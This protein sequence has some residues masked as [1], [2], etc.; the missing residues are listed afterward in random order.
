MDILQNKAQRSLYEGALGIDMPSSSMGD[1]LRERTRSNA[2][3]SLFFFTTAVLGWNKLKQVPHL[4]LC[5][6]IQQVTPPF[7]R[8]KVVLIPR[9]CYKS[10]IGSK[11]LP[12]WILVQKDFLGL[13]GPEHRILLVSHSSVNAQKQIKS[14]RQ[15]IERNQ[16]LQ[17]L[18]PELIP[19]L[20]KTT[21]TDTNLLFPRQGVYGEDT[22][23]CA[24][25]DTHLVSRHYTV[26]I[27]DDMEDEAAMQSPTVRQRVISWYKAA[28]ALFVDERDAFD[29]LI[30]TRWGIDDLYSEIIKNESETY[31]F[32]VR[33]LHWT[34]QELDEDVRIAKES[35]QPRV[36]GD[37][38]PEVHAPDPAETYYFF[39]DL[40]PQDSCRRVRA[41]QGSYMY[42]MLYLNNPKDPALAEFRERDFRYFIFDDEGNLII[43]EEDG[44]HSI[45]PFD[46]LKRVLFWDP[47]MS[48]TEHKKNA[49]NAM[50]VLGKDRFGRLFVLDVYA[51]WKNPAFLFSKYVGL[52]QR[53]ACHKAGIEDVAF[54]RVLRFP[55][56]QVMRELGIH[57]KVEELRP[58]GEKDK[59]IRSLL[60]YVESHL[61]FINRKCKDFVEEM[62]GFPVFP[63]KDIIDAAAGCLPLFG[64]QAVDIR[65]LEDRVVRR[66]EGD[67]LTTRSALTGY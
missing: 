24:G 37:M 14:L 25:I 66:E 53:Y 34:R 19:D 29:C 10:T 56:N 8:R 58:I 22:I 32:L 64:M 3:R 11:S 52:H 31:Q 1:E 61:L 62:R 13:P 47:A 7:G 43:E 51:E 5:E 42:S 2:Q 59:R 45:V 35:S 30:G 12:L 4:E 15:Q 60:P 17:W 20:S 41:K 44:S 57:F 46:S 36:Y 26:Q 33:P 65:R 38:I 55:L 21:W 18:F 6:F 49:R 54:Q 63:T 27:K 48:E 9:D 23:E 39:P 50:V 28:E 16:I 67:R 40:F